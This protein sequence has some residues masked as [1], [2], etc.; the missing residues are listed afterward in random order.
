MALVSVIMAT[1]NIPDTQILRT[2]INSVLRQTFSN[3]ELIICDD[4]STNDTYELLQEISRQDDRIILVRNQINMGAAVARNA[5]IR[6]AGGKF[7]AIMDSDDFSAPCRLQ[8][9]VQFLIDFPE[10]DFV[11]VKGQYFNLWPYENLGIYWFCQRPREIDFLFTL[12]FVHAS[13]M[14]RREAL[15][16]IGG[17]T[18]ARVATRSEDYDLLMRLYAAGYRGANIP[19]V[20][21]LIRL[22]DNTYKRRRYKYRFNECVVKYKGFKTLGLMPRGLVYALKPL[23][24]GLIPVQLLRW[25][26]L[27]YYK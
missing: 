26:K 10:Y 13:L 21:Y 27:K 22:D 4:G 23:I 12:P 5:C 18:E 16:A 19:E 14:F 7:I 15:E 9:E 6:L 17:Y 20:L 11:G 8:K 1:Y 3:F 24:V 25:M 2:A